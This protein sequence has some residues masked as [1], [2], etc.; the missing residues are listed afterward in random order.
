MCDEAAYGNRTRASG[1]GSPRSTTEPMRHCRRRRSRLARVGGWTPFHRP[2]R[3]D[4]FGRR[5][6]V[7]QNR[8]GV[9]GLRDRWSTIDPRR[10]VPC[11]RSAAKGSLCLKGKWPPAWR[12]PE[13]DS[14]LRPPPCDGGALPLSYPG[15]SRVSPVASGFG[16]GLPPAR[17]ATLQ[18]PRSSQRMGFRPALRR[19][20][21]GHIIISP[22]ELMSSVFPDLRPVTFAGLPE[23]V[24][25]ELTEGF[26][27]A[28]FKPVPIDHS[29]TAL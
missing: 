24:R 12:C 28:G 25:F 13:E 20:G 5:T 23:R 22:A 14:D 4:V 3:P 15:W 21:M 8:T 1:L 16:D 10:Q 17:C 9:S 7:C 19:C 29:G 18:R 2:D 27:S 6:A 11:G 26:P